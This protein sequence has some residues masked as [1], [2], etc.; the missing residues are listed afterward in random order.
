MRTKKYDYRNCQSLFGY[1]M[2]IHKRS[3]GIC[4]LCGAGA[5]ITINFD[6]WR[7][8]T[9]EHLIGTS[10]GGEYKQILHALKAKFPNKDNHVL[11]ERAQL[12]E[13]EN[14][15]TACSFCNAATS[16][17]KHSRTMADVIRQAEPS[18]KD[19]RKAVRVECRV[20]L[21]RKKDDIA[22]KLEAIRERF[23]GRVKKDL[24][25]VRKRRSV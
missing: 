3:G 22:W 24:L 2:A 19:A 23:N 4:Q 20:I 12:L 8:L 17:M 7:Q 6:F 1:A 5:G 18:W 14:M 15:V 25:G 11:E 9:V 21:K 13:T 16:R 10:Q